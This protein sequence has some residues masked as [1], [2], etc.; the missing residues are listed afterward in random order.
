[1]GVKRVLWTGGQDSTFRVMQ[2]CNQGV[3]VQP[4]YVLDTERKSTTN[5]IKAINFIKK[6]LSTK[7]SSSLIKDTIFID[8]NDIN[9]T[10]ETIK[11]FEKLKTEKYIGCQYN[12]LCELSKKYPDIEL[13]VHKDDKATF[14]ITKEKGDGNYNESQYIFQN[15]SFPLLNYT[16]LQMKKEA[17]DIDCDKVLDLSWFCHDPIK[18]KPCGICNPCKYTF[19]EGMS[20]RFKFQAKL[21]YHC[22]WFF[23]PLRKVL[24]FLT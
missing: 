7:F 24:N 10:S 22:R 14:F 18:N 11:N 5:E 15:F 17:H 20:C 8:I 2:L 19:E 16:K 23:A 9:V 6:E 3:E 13:C 12:W 21:Y 1:M 4:V